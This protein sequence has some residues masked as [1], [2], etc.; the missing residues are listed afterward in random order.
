MKSPPDVSGEVS[1][2]W[3]GPLTE[4]GAEAVAVGVAV[5]GEH[6]ARHGRVLVRREAVGDG[7]RSGVGEVQERVHV[8]AAGEVVAAFEGHGALGGG[9]G[10]GVEVEA[11]ADGPLAVVAAG[12]V[13]AGAVGCGARVHLVAWPRADEVRRRGVVVGL[14]STKRTQLK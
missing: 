11:R 10:D 13:R 7:G 8:L 4:R 3:L 14:G 2:P 1:V 12:A 5:V 6:V 9:E